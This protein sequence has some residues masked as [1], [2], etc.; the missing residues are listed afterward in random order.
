MTYLQTIHSCLLVD[1]ALLA[2]TLPASAGA[3]DRPNWLLPV[4]EEAAR[5]V[6]PL[7][8]DMEA[9]YE[10]GQLTD[11]M[12]MF[13]AVRPQVHVSIVDTDLS[14]AAFTEHLRR[15][16][17][18]RTDDGRAFTLRFADC[19][20]LPVLAATFSAEQWTS[21]AGPVK[22]WCVH[23]RDGALRDLPLPDR[24][25]P[26]CSTPLALTARQ[27]ADLA[28]ATAP[29]EMLADIREM[30]H[31]RGMRGSA[32]EQHRWAT[33]ARR[34]WRSAGSSDR[35]VLRWLTEAVLDSGGA[36]LGQSGLSSLLALN[37]TAAIRAGLKDAVERAD[38]R[39]A[40][41]PDGAPKTV[42]RSAGSV[43]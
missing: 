13:N 17:M 2:P 23:G 19:L 20:G 32:S 24:E 37:D 10:S 30:R 4:Y 25:L 39:P 36:V 5:A 16:I 31:D 12:A 9:A 34:L 11:M 40:H 35:L 7:V 27:L 22:R 41:R 6:S 3:V 29:D 1:G 8:I 42:G 14:P 18:I 26:P 43:R 21:F 38:T 15:F 33:D 28:E